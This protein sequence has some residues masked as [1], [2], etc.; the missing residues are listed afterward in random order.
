MN[1]SE[2]IKELATALSKAQG[3]I[4]GVTKDTVNP[5]YKA[6]YATLSACLDA[7]REPLTKNG[8]SIVQVNEATP[9]ACTV[10]TILMHSSGEWISGTMSIKPVKIDPQ[11]FGSA[12]TYARR[13]GLM[14]IIGLAPEDDDGNLASKGVPEEPK[15]L[16]KAE[17]IEKMKTAANVFELKARWEKYAH[18]Y[19]LLSKEDQV[20]VRMSKD[21]AKVVLDA[22]TAKGDK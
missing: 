21:K 12:M 5:F 6:A 13:Y 9:E 18:D 4:K 20:D 19:S 7:V 16:N 2:S 10:E 14:A 1:K 11:Q 8:L 17:L 15:H 22:E 3:T